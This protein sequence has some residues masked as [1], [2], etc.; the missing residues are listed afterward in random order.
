LAVFSALQPSSFNLRVESPFPPARVI[1]R[2]IFDIFDMFASQILEHLLRDD[3]LLRVRTHMQQTQ[4]ILLV[5]FQSGLESGRVV[6][7]PMVPMGY[8]GLFFVLGSNGQSCGIRLEGFES[9]VGDE[10]G[11]CPGSS[12]GIKPIAQSSL[13]PQDIHCVGALVIQ[14]P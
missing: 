12:S 6:T 4:D 14:T 9:R 8:S 7:Q 13:Y 11:S 5:L 2:F 10:Q 3:R 1:S